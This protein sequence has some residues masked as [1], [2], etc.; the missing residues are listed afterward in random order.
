MMK[1][2]TVILVILSCAFMMC[3]QVSQE[4]PVELVSCE[5]EPD[6]FVNNWTAIIPID[7]PPRAPFRLLHGEPLF[8]IHR[9]SDSPENQARI[10]FFVSM[11]TVGDIDYQAGSAPGVEGATKQVV[12]ALN[13]L[14]FSN[15]GWGSITMTLYY[16]SH[17]AE[18]DFTKFQFLKGVKLDRDSFR[19]GFQNPDVNIKFVL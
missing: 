10:T 4:S 7:P 17:K 9:P 3:R 5:R 12:N 19:R 6:G 2:L 15:N 16:G 14:Q 18:L 11:G 8:L 13:T 1:K